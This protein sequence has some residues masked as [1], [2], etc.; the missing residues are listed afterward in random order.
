MFRSATDEDLKV[1]LGKFLSQSYDEIVKYEMV[2]GE[3]FLTT[4]VTR[5]LQTLNITR[6]WS[7][8][9][10]GIL[11]DARRYRDRVNQLV[12]GKKALFEQS[13]IEYIRD[14]RPNMPA[15]L[16]GQERKS[17]AALMNKEKHEDWQEWEGYAGE[18]RSLI[19][20]LNSR[21]KDL[22]SAKQDLRAQLWAVKLQGIL[23]ELSDEGGLEDRNPNVMG[24]KMSTDRVVS[25]PGCNKN[26]PVFAGGKVGESIKTAGLNIDSI[27][28]KK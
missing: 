25:P 14:N 21:H 16:D 20:T 26:K 3:D 2:L 24:Y 22:L 7:N 8:R 5:F 12:R 19:D 6:G 23:G 11:M 4:G 15:G 1:I 9:V 10:L 28:G 18:L 13:C 27:L 17:L